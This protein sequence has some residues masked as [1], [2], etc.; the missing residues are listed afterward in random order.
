MITAYFTVVTV[1]FFASIVAS[2]A[3]AVATPHLG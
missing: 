2:A 1:V 3:V